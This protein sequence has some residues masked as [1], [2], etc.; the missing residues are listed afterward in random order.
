[1]ISTEHGVQGFLIRLARISDDAL[2]LLAS[3]DP[4]VAPGKG[5]PA[6]E[7]YQVKMFPTTTESDSPLAI[8]AHVLKYFIG[9]LNDIN[10][11][12][13]RDNL[14]MTSD[15]EMKPKAL[16][17]LDEAHLVLDE[18]EKRLKRAFQPG[19][20][21]V[22][23]H[24]HNLSLAGVA[25]PERGQLTDPVQ[26]KA[27]LEEL[28]SIAYAKQASIEALTTIYSVTS[29][30]LSAHETL[31]RS[32]H[33]FTRGERAKTASAGDMRSNIMDMVMHAKALISDAAKFLATFNVRDPEGA[34]NGLAILEQAMKAIL[35]LSAACSATHRVVSEKV[36]SLAPIFEAIKEL[37]SVRGD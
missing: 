15:E 25:I 6:G 5:T 7:A 29:E 12:G 18:Y 32:Y 30:L 21:S 23:D 19:S 24:I 33:E 1:M 10:K 11:G 17:V 26:R 31:L 3:D 8:I 36:A 37:E 34:P 35:D 14:K 9:V 16:D 20:P 4:S 13:T 2:L 28:Q 22:S 27:K